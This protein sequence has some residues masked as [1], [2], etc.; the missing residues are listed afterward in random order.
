MDAAPVPGDRPLAHRGA[1]PVRL[2]DQPARHPPL[3]AGLRPTADGD[4]VRRQPDSDS[5]TDRDA[6][7]IRPTVARGIERP[8]ACGQPDRHATVRAPALAP[9]LSSVTFVDV[10]MGWAAGRGVILGTT[11]GGKSWHAEWTGTRSISSLTAVDRVH[12]WGL[13]SGTTAPAAH[14]LVRTADGGRTWTMTTLPRAFRA[15]AFTTHLAGWAVVG[16]I[17]ETTAGPGRLER[18]VD[19]GTHWRSATLTAPVTSV[20]FASPSLGWAAGGV[21][22][23]RTLDGGRRWTRVGRGSNTPTDPGWQATIHCRGSAAWVLSIGGAGLG[24]GCIASRARSMVGAL[25][26]RRRSMG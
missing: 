10:A 23:Y 6:E 24:S 5:D 13:A 14:W 2:C 1:R 25:A 17:T 4:P 11:D 20:C 21:G 3:A 26:D 9:P 16:G 8:D 15:I 7:P 12:A 22:I 18:T 19:A